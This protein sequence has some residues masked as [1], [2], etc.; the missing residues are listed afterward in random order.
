MK[1][2]LILLLLPILTF[3]QKEVVIM[4][5][6]DTY[7]SETRWVLYDSVYQGPILSEVQYGHYTQPSTMNYDTVYIPDSIN[8]I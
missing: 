3:A 2:I 1:K 8:N 5:K 4:V 6:T 7:P